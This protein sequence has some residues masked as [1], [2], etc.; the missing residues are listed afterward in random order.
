MMTAAP[1][2]WVVVFAALGAPGGLSAQA[3]NWSGTIKI[4]QIASKQ[5]LQDDKVMTTSATKQAIT[6]SVLITVTN[7]QASADINF[8]LDENTIQQDKY[9]GYTLDGTNAEK[10][11][12]IGTNKTDS[13]VSVSI[14]PD[15]RFEIEYRAGGVTGDYQKTQTTVI[16]CNGR[17][18]NCRAS[19]SKDSDA[20]KPANLGYVAGTIDGTINKSTPNVLSGTMTEPFDYFDGS[21]GKTTITWNLKR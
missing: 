3:K 20:A 9:D 14:Y 2:L 18:P 13:R 15:G 10:T 16:T 7:G 11:T 4:T 1:L 6:N 19:T 5:T 12:A 21:P 17:D 8:L